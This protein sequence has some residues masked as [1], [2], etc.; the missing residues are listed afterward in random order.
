MSYARTLIVTE[1]MYN[2]ASEP[3]GHWEYVELYNWGDEAIDLA[4]WCFD[5]D[6]VSPL[7]AANI[8]SG[9]IPPG[10]T[11]LLFNA[12]DNSVAAM[13][14]AWGTVINW[15][16]VTAWPEL[17]NTGGRIGL[18]SSLDT[19]AG[20][21]FNKSVQDITYVNATPWPEDDDQASV[22]LVDYET[23]Q[24]RGESWALSVSSVDGAYESNPAGD[25]D[26]VNLGSPSYTF[27]PFV[28][29]AGRSLRV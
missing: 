14:A 3:D 18:W 28:P 5:R 11:A 17:D 10:E 8:A 16:A 26:A 15:V 29:A 7:A 24:L 25:N 21:D 12:D 27:A 20:R 4:G 9:T 22:Y 2:P 1:I 13:E 19:Y 23:D 6:G